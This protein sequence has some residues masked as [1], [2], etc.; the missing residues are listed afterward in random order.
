MMA[1]SD[2]R[3]ILRELWKIW[4]KTHD[5]GDDNEQ[6]AQ[7]LLGSLRWWTQLIVENVAPLAAPGKKPVYFP[8]QKGI[9]NTWFAIEPKDSEVRRGQVNI[10]NVDEEGQ[11]KNCYTL[12]GD[13]FP[14][15]SHH[16]VYKVFYHGTRAKHAKCIIEDGID[17]S[18]GGRNKDF[19]DGD[20]FYV[21]DKFAPNAIWALRRPPCSTV[22][23]F[24][25][26]KDDLSDLRR[27]NLTENT[28]EV[29][30]KW[31]EVVCTFRDGEATER[32][33]KGLNADYIEGPVCGNVKSAKCYTPTEVYQLCV[34]SERCVE[35][36]N[37]GLHSVIFF[38]K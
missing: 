5:A 23:I 2:V 18:A 22:L 30:E 36:F 21:T 6:T 35:L 8:Y 9:I 26:K 33:K 4:L 31:K 14:K 16:D 34:R 15:P 28:K 7:S 12:A 17:L 3:L 24:K 1:A 38:D 19:S 37:R 25:I 11:R 13:K 20:G 32:Y 29:R 27:L 10:I